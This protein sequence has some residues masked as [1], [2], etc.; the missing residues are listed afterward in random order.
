[1]KKKSYKKIIIKRYGKVSCI[2]GIL[3]LDKF[4]KKI[5]IF[6]IYFELYIL[7]RLFCKLKTGE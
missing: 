6:D 5:V 1:M 2:D 3:V 4:K 7:F